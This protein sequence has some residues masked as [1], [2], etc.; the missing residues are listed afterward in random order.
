MSDPYNV[1][2]TDFAD[3]G[4]VAVAYSKPVQG[5][6]TSRTPGSILHRMIEK[7]HGKCPVGC[8]D[9]SWEDNPFTGE[10]EWMWRRSEDAYEDRRLRAKR[11]SLCRARKEF[12]AIARGNDWTGGM[13][14]TLTFNDALVN[15]FDYDAISSAWSRF[16]KEM[17]RLNPH[18]EYLACPEM[19]PTS[20][21]WHIH[22]LVRGAKF[23]LVDSGKKTKDHYHL[24]IYNIP[25][26]WPYGFATATYIR[27]ASRVASYICK[28]MGKDLAAIPSGRRRFWASKSL[29][30]LEDLSE[31]MLLDHEERQNLVE[32]LE[33]IADKVHRVFVQ[34]INM[35]VTYYTVYG[36]DA[37]EPLPST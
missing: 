7:E 33:S 2:K 37:S 34:A 19:H 14:V 21:R 35:W 31:T 12:E 15:G 3:G 20:G 17:L 25:L 23:R 11:V 27:S 36:S 8:L 16:A 9:G 6:D 29:K 32:Y 1:R 5:R 18:L 4:Y 10:P 22:C 30:R 24:T 26:D 28:Y 13:F